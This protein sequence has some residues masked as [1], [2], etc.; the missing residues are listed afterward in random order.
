METKVGYSL[1]FV[2]TVCSNFT[3]NLESLEVY[4]GLALD[5]RFGVDLGFKFELQQ[6]IRLIQSPGVII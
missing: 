6:R 5:G 4:L 3:K 2:K 1:T